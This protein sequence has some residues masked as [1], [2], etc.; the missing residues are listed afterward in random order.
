MTALYNV[1]KKE[2]SGEELTKKE[3]DIHEKGLVGVLD[4]LHD[5]LDAAVARAYG[6][7][8]GLEKEEILQRLVDLNEKRRAEEEEGHVRWL[9]P[10]YQAPEE[11]ETQAALDLDVEISTEGEVA[12]SLAWPSELKERAQAIRTVM[13]ASEEPLTVEE[14]A[15]HFH[16]A[17]RDD[18]RGILETLSGLGLL[19]KKRSG[20]EEEDEIFMA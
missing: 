6:W 18:V 19:D 8:P 11:M 13:D 20:E 16:R 17:R 12:Q 4:E 5:E 15:Q 2:Q 1:L 10:E 9:R 7:E 3:R 14:V